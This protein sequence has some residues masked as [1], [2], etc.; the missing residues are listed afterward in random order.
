MDA[1]LQI[2]EFVS[3]ESDAC[4]QIPE[5]VRYGIN[6]LRITAQLGGAS[7]ALR[8]ALLGAGLPAAIRV[9]RSLATE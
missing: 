3:T 6:A 9:L 2:P 1:C 7:E 8:T 5:F 4:L